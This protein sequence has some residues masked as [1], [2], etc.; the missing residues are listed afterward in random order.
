MPS[1]SAHYYRQVQEEPLSRGCWLMSKVMS[2]EIANILNSGNPNAPERHS[3]LSRG[4]HVL[5]NP[6]AYMQIQGIL[7]INIILK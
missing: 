1:Q 7:I 4:Q 2:R 6:I 3:S 5:L